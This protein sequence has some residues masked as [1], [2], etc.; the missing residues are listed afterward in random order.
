MPDYLAIYD[1]AN[2]E[3]ARS[4]E[5][6]QQTSLG[7]WPTIRPHFTARRNGAFERISRH[8]PK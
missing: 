4:P 1:I 3:T 8:G 2:P 5:W 7:A 6:K